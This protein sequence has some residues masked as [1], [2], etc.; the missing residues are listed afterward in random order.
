MDQAEAEVEAEAGGENYASM[1]AAQVDVEVEVQ[2]PRIVAFDIETTG[3]NLHTDR[4]TCAAIYGMDTA[5][6]VYSKVWH[7]LSN[8]QNE[9]RLNQDKC[10]KALDDCE[11]I[12]TH[13]G[14]SFD[15]P[16][17][18]RLGSYCSQSGLIPN[19]P[20]CDVPFSATGA[21][22][23]RIQRWMGK[24]FDCF[25]IIRSELGSWVKLDDLLKANSLATKTGT[26]L[27]AI[28]WARTRQMDKL[29]EY[30]LTDARLTYALCTLEQI[31][32]PPPNNRRVIVS[33]Q[34]QWI[35]RSDRNDQVSGLQSPN[36]DIAPKEQSSG[37]QSG[38]P[39]S[40]RQ[41]T[42]SSNRSSAAPRQQEQALPHRSPSPGISDTNQQT[43]WLNQEV[44][45][46][47]FQINELESNPTAST[48]LV[49]LLQK[50]IDGLQAQITDLEENRSTEGNAQPV[51]GTIVSNGVELTMGSGRMPRQND[52]K[53]LTFGNETKCNDAVRPGIRGKLFH[54]EYISRFI[55]G[56]R[57]FTPETTECLGSMQ[58]MIW[59]AL[60]DFGL[61]RGWEWLG[62]EVGTGNK[63][64]E[65]ELYIDAAAQCVSGR[66]KGAI[67]FFEWKTFDPISPHVVSGHESAAKEQ[68]YNAYR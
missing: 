63:G 40:A 3:T 14:I 34:V 60:D 42:S 49:Q 32:L 43:E 12:L 66:K 11:E 8:D 57:N 53:T 48:G 22:Q 17:M 38:G 7:F 41:A 10:M 39:Q 27:Q 62:A 16:F 31:R 9:R 24:T 2:R 25:E 1:D 58:E 37:P 68:L 28:E 55:R 30:C 44:A 21:N 35:H 5:G 52:S 33:G 4:V 20:F 65:K 26:G 51:W 19:T 59:K 18:R 13:C 23:D 61:G 64:L 50:Q 15:L 46:L 56:S 54:D 29:T 6:K 47:R 45:R 67:S 36:Q